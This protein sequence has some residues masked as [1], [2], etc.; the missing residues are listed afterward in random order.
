MNRPA[1]AAL[2]AALAWGAVAC[3]SGDG[4]PNPSAPDSGAHVDAPAAPDVVRDTRATADDAIDAPSPSPDVASDGE[5]ADVRD[6]SAETSADAMTR[7]DATDALVDALAAQDAALPDARGDVFDANSG[8]AP[9]CFHHSQGASPSAYSA[10]VPR[11]AP[12]GALAQVWAA[13]SGAN[14]SLFVRFGGLDGGFSQ[15]PIAPIAGSSR[16]A[17]VARNGSRF[18]SVYASASGDAGT[19]ILFLTFDANVTPDA[20]ASPVVVGDGTLPLLARGVSEYGLAW[21]TNST[22]AFARIS[23]AGALLDAPQPLAGRPILVARTGSEY[24]VVHLPSAPFAAPADVKLARFSASTG[25]RI[26]ADVTLA[27]YLSNTGVAPAATGDGYVLAWWEP[28]L[29]SGLPNRRLARYDAAGATL[30]KKAAGSGEAAAWS[31]KEI[32]LLY[33]TTSGSG[34]GIRANA[35]LE[36]YTDTGD[37]IPGMQVDSLGIADPRGSTLVWTGS[38][39]SYSYLSEVQGSS[40]SIEIGID[41]FVGNGLPIN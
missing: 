9:G 6:A 5:G 2:L 11:I 31:G 36:R 7:A 28:D 37:P 40:R 1:R 38:R 39:Y 41:C 17:D 21:F 18:A 25:Q 23:D 24:G 19:S 3:G 20:G 34:L 15:T 13:S 4:D 26:G 33:F 32:A 10:S 27:T 12:G 22:Y 8:P 14:P 30:W 16:A 35:R 29:D